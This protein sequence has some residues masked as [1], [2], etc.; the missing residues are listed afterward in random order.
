MWWRKM[1]SGGA[2]DHGGPTGIAV[3]TQKG[4]ASKEMEEKNKHFDKCL[5][6]GRRISGTF[7]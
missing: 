1:N 2:A 3:L 4:T 7:V 6:L 5:S